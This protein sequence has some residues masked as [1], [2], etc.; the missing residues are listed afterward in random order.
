MPL[1]TPPT[2]V[3]IVVKTFF[4]LKLVT[5]HI[6]LKG[7]SV[8]QNTAKRLTLHPYKGIWTVGPLE[9][10]FLYFENCIYHNYDVASVSETTPCDKIG[11][12]LVVYRFSGNVMA[13][14]STFKII[15]F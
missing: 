12:P 5:L 9:L 1:L 15:T 7:K 13:F 8:E 2:P 11:K 3:G 6:K 14:K 10:Y 4:F